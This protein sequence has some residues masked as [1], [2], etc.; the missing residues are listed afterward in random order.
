MGSR[1]ARAIAWLGGRETGRGT[2]KVTNERQDG[3]S[4]VNAA[5]AS[6]GLEALGTEPTNAQG[7]FLNA[8]G[9]GTTGS[10]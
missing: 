10:C 3:R 1:G 9:Q 5:A 7:I 6:L 8:P 2:L 4:N